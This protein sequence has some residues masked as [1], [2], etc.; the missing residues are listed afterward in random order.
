M[1]FPALTTNISFPGNRLLDL[2]D[3]PSVCHNIFVEYQGITVFYLVD[4]HY[5]HDEDVYYIHV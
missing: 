1:Q 5:K 4:L 3:L 2:F